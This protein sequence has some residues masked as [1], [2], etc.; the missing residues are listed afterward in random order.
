MAPI[1]LHVSNYQVR[2]NNDSY[3][4]ADFVVCIERAGSILLHS[5]PLL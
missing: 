3:S 1:I 5:F 2:I 4:K